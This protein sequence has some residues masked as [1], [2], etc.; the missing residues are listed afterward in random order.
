MINPFSELFETLAPI[1]LCGLELKVRRFRSGSNMITLMPVHVDDWGPYSV[2]WTAF[3]LEGKQAGSLC[4]VLLPAFPAGGLFHG[5][6][7][8]LD[9]LMARLKE[10]GHLEAAAHL[11]PPVLIKLPVGKDPAMVWGDWV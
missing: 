7:S 4:A 5:P 3:D 6:L 11:H 9:P 10:S 8:Q 1:T 2:Q